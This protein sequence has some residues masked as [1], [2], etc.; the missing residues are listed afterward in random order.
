VKRREF[1]I[2]VG[3]A[4]VAQLVRPRVARLLIDAL[5]ESAGIRTVMAELVAGR[6]AYSSLK[7]SLA[8]TFEV[9]L[10]WRLLTAS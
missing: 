5:T 3:S 2:L 1:A 10:A 9:G 4:A 8:G 6:R 7:W